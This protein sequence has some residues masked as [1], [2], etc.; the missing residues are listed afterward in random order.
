MAKVLV[1]GGTRFVSRCVAEYFR[2]RGDDIYVL[3]RG[4]T[5]SP[6]GV[7]LIKSDRH[8]LGDKLR[9]MHFEAVI[10]V[11]AYNKTDVEDLKKAMDCECTYVLISSSAVYPEWEA[12]PFAEDASRDLNKFWKTYGTDK[13]AAEDMALTSFED[14]YVIRPPYIYGEGN[15]LYREGFI[16]DCAEQDRK[17]YLPGNGDMRLQFFHVYDLCRFIAALLE[18]KPEEKV[19]NVGNSEV[20]TIKEWVKACYKVLGKE[21]SFVNVTSGIE[22]RLYFPFY[23]YEY[24]LDVTRM[25][26]LLPDTIS[27]EE[28]LDLSYKWYRNNRDQV[29][30]KPLISYIEEELT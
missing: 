27:L 9:G 21:P 26:A 19:Y 23:N 7:T 13:I 22:Q 17:F 24:I 18:K 4:N 15:N 5:P 25:K 11:C 2:D 3:N 29:N 6:S 1:T 12:Q 30:I 8:E 28:G 16:F 10:D 20:V 14:C